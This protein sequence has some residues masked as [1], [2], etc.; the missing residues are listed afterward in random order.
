MGNAN[1]VAN[2]L[3][4]YV[5]EALSNNEK[6]IFKRGYELKDIIK[7]AD[8]PNSVLSQNGGLTDGTSTTTYSIADLYDL[9]KTF[10][11]E[12]CGNA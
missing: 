9:V 12:T 11:E 4:V 7:V 6:V 1:N 8:L 10:D 3:K 2:L 5:E